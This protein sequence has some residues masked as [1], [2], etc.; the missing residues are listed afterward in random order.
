MTRSHGWCLVLSL[1][2]GLMTLTPAVMRSE[3]QASPAA[4]CVALPLASLRGAE[5]N[6]TDLSTGIR[7]LV[8]SFLSGPSLRTVM[9]AA[10]LPEQALEEAK[11]KD[12]ES[13]LTLTLTRETSGGAGFGRAL[14][15]AASAAAWHLPY[16]ATVGSSAARSAAAGGAAA[17]SSIASNTR[18]KDEWQLEY[19]LVRG[20]I[21]I[22]ARK[23]RAKARTDGEDLVTPLVER[24]ATAVA[25]AIA[26]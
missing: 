14:G 13:L 12:C 22:G 10:R 17:A 2:S 20:A 18:A 15:A 26:K 8:A 3:T 23:D 1:V 25:A 5:T 11:Q 24:M 4:R 6:T 16:G 21:V 19:R 7:E 9:L